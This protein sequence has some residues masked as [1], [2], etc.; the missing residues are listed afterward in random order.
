MSSSLHKSFALSSVIYIVC[1][2]SFIV[3]V[4]QIESSTRKRTINICSFQEE[5][6]SPKT[7]SPVP[8]PQKTVERKLAKSIKPL[9]S[10]YAPTETTQA[11]KTDSVNKTIEQQSI[12][13][14]KEQ[15]PERKTGNEVIKQLV[16]DESKNNIAR[17][18]ELIEKYKQYPRIARTMGYEGV[19]IVSFKLYPDGSIKDMYVAKSSGFPSLDTSS[20]TAIKEAMHEMP[21]PNKVMPYSIPIEY[22]LR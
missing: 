15:G 22:A 21:R 12:V 17:I 5:C 20:T 13:S 9:T 7:I 18:R 10:T 16:I 4:H 11:E 6:L 2:T 3:G 14:T 1:F 19:C 8:V